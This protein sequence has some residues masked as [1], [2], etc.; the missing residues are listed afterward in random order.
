MGK[1]LNKD[2]QSLNSL[3]STGYQGCLPDTVIISL[4][5]L[6]PHLSPHQNVMEPAI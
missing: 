4:H 6:R 1:D 5:F 3:G 2:V